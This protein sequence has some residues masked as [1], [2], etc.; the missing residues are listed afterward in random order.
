M[1]FKTLLQDLKAAGLTQKQVAERCGCS[2]VTVSDLA[3]GV[4]NDPSFSIGR[5]I[6]ALHARKAKRRKVAETV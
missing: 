4:T 6:V 2:Q 3:R 5:C 1:D